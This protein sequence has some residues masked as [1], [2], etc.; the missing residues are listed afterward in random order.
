MGIHMEGNEAN[1]DS[2][3]FVQSG[4][5]VFK[6][7]NSHIFTRILTNSKVKNCMSWRAVENCWICERWQE[8]EFRWVP[9]ESGAE[10]KPPIYIHFD[11]D[12]FDHDLL[13][14]NPDGSFSV[15][16]MVPPKKIKYFFTCNGTARVGHDRP[17]EPLPKPY[18]R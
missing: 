15:V 16:R 1:V 13:D 14:E 17:T 5:A 11:F 10:S 8:V 6:A 2:L 3:G 12:N 7:K 9:G 4:G 18:N